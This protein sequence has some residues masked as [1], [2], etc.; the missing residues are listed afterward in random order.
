M[1]RNRMIDAM[2]LQGQV[3]S[4]GLFGFEIY[5]R[6]KANDVINSSTVESLGKTV[7]LKYDQQIN[8]HGNLTCVR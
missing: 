3:P 7:L 5:G 4:C 6:I 8:R 1:A 2:S